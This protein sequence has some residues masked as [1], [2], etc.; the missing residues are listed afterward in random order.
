[1][2][3]AA[4]IAERA[5]DAPLVV[6]INGA[7]GSGKTTLCRLLEVILQQG[8]GKRVA[9]LSID[10]LY[11]TKAQRQQ[12]AADIH[13]LLITRGVPGTHDIALG[14]ETIAAAKALGAAGTAAMPRFDKSIDDR[15]AEPSSHEAPLDVLLFEGWCVGSVPQIDVD[16]A[17]PVNDLE[18]DEDP[19]GAWRRYVNEK[20]RGEYQEL[21][22]LLDAL[23]ML[24]VPGMAQ[25]REW[26][27]KQE[28]ELPE[29]SR[30]TDAELA[31]FIAHYE[32]ITLHT[33]SEMPSRADIVLDVAHDQQVRVPDGWP[34]LS[35]CPD[36]GE[37]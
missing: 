25:V 32:R 26:R 15:A 30:M 28:Q 14:I 18:R 3:L 16:L 12:L 33:L 7:Q 36:S 9:T 27:G 10:D 21:F 35:G 8:F 24:R 29:E 13:P 1:M 17:D 6:G 37:H 22:A 20:L 2:P 5:G 34:L 31:R 11:C 19:D 4:W 23:V